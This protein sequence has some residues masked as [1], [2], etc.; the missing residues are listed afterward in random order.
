MRSGT[1]R[2]NVTRMLAQL[3]TSPNGHKLAAFLGRDTLLLVACTR[4]GSYGDVAPAGLTGR[5]CP[6]YF[7]SPQAAARWV[8]LR[9]KGKHPKA[10][11]RGCTKLYQADLGAHTRMRSRESTAGNVVLHRS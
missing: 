5:Q 1:A 10:E 2:K 9:D 3:E 4:C 11:R 7:P 8:A 6:G